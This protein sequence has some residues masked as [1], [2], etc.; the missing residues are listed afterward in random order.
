MVSIFDETREISDW[1]SAMFLNWLIE[2]MG[3]LDP[4]FPKEKK[5]TKP[6]DDTMIDSEMMIAENTVSAFVSVFSLNLARPR[7]RFV[8]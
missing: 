4:S 2:S 3:R 7:F 6:A 1:R 8:G 5:V